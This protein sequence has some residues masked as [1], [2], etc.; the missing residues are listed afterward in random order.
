MKLSWLLAFSVVLALPFVKAADPLP[1]WNESPAKSAIVAFVH[2][3]TSKGTEGYVSTSE[4]IAAFGNSD[5]D[6]QMLQWTVAGEGPCFCLLVHHTDADREWAYDRE[7]TIGRR[8]NAL[9]EAREKAW[10]VVD[11]RK[12]WKTVYSSKMTK[13]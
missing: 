13:R 3:V 6:L 10:T 11:M 4:R 1:S 5:G 12:D 7:S 9:S 2:R 8:D